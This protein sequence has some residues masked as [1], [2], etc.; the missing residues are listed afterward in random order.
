[1]VMDE[2]E[3]F[4]WAEIFLEPWGSLLDKMSDRASAMGMTQEASDRVLI[5]RRDTTEECRWAFLNDP[6]DVDAVRAVFNSEEN[7]QS[8]AC[9]VVVR[10]D[11]PSESRGENVFDIFRLSPKSLL[12]HFHRVHTR[13]GGV[14]G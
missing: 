11:D 5:W 2:E 3:C 13:P 6:A 14:S 4:A 12:W 7:V 9:F 8:P 10:Q 1:M